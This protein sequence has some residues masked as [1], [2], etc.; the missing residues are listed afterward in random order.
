MDYATEMKR[1]AELLKKYSHRWGDNPSQRMLDWVDRYNTLR[2]DRAKFEA[3]CTENGFDPSHD[4][5]DCL[6]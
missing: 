6:A 5:Y 4:A 2:E 1:L 3:Y